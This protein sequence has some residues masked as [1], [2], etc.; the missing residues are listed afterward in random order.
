MDRLVEVLL[1][2]LLEVL[3]AVEGGALGDSWL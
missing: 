3:P 1:T 2:G